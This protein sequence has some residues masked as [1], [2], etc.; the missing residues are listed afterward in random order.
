MSCHTT[1][2]T[3]EPEILDALSPDDPRA[4]RSRR[5]LRHIN[6][7]MGNHRIMAKAL[8][9][10]LSGAPRNIAELG[11]GDGHFLLTVAQKLAWQDVNAILVERQNAFLSK[12]LAGFSK[13]H[14][15]AEAVV[16]DVFDW[17]G[18]AEIVITNL[19]IHQFENAKLAQL[20]QK[21]SRHA[22]LFIAVEPH[23][24]YFPYL[25]ALTTLLIGCSQTTIHDAEASIRAGFM[26]TEISELWP[27]KTNWKLTERRAGLFSHLF[28]AKRV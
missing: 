18:H 13:T 10:N 26:S 6:F 21:I 15:R 4:V 20:I 5:D 2:R 23:R 12:V 22:K 14:W 16:A 17:D 7:F 28:L 11:A 19:F 24:F 27:D 1:S 9:E 25:C 8:K 3:V